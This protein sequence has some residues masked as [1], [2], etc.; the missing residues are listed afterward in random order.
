MLHQH[1]QVVCWNLGKGVLPLKVVVLFG[2]CLRGQVRYNQ[3][4]VVSVDMSCWCNSNRY[5]GK[6]PYPCALRVFW[7]MPNSQSPLPVSRTRASHIFHV[8]QLSV[9]VS[10]WAVDPKRIRYRSV[11]KQKNGPYHLPGVPA[12]GDGTGGAFPEGYQRS[13]AKDNLEIRPVFFRPTCLRIPPDPT[14]SRRN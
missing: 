9:I 4:G 12:V 7:P 14:T 3:N 10:D 2:N 5:Q 8:K 11:G 1:T 6:A 13:H